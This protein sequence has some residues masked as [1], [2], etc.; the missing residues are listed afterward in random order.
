MFKAPKSDFDIQFGQP[1][2]RSAGHMDDYPGFDWLRIVLASGV[3]WVHAGS[4]EH[5]NFAGDFFVQ[6]FFALSGFLIGGIILRMK[7]TDLPRFFYNRTIRIWLPFLAAVAIL[8]LTAYLKEGFAPYFWHSLAFDLT[9]THNYFIAKAPEVIA[10]LPINGTGSHFWSIAVEEQFYLL[11]PILILFVPLA[12]YWATWVLIAIVATVL[13]TF[14]GSVSA[15]VL[16]A[17]LNRRFGNW[18]LHPLAIALFICVAIMVSGLW[19]LDIFEYRYMIPIFAIVTVLLCARPGQRTAFGKWIGGISFPMYLN[20]WIGLFVA[21]AIASRLPNLG[22]LTADIFGFALSIAVAALAY[23]L[24]DRNLYTYRS[25]WYAPALGITAVMAA[26]T[27]MALGLIF[28]L[29][30]IGP[31]TGPA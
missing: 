15:G 27:L 31:L 11:A 9:F 13:G 2:G 21:A 12:K 20:H 30:A 7:P 19:A 25:S 8:Y 29:Y 1:V 22:V 6:V 16:G 18:H 23:R 14:Y 26:Y 4:V 24:I 3:F 10:Q 17:M 28:G 5:F